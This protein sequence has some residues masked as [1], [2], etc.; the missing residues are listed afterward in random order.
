MYVFHNSKHFNFF[1]ENRWL[2]R[3]KLETEVIM[4]VEKNLLDTR[5]ENHIHYP[6]SVAIYI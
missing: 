2:S 6:W 4:S 3:K 5:E 1:L